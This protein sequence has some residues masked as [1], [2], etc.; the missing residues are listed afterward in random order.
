MG[1]TIS[2]TAITV[3]NTACGRWR[4]T[5][6]QD[7]FRDALDNFVRGDSADITVQEEDSAATPKRF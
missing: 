7:T 2:P 1:V 5:F 4:E 3:K 6:N